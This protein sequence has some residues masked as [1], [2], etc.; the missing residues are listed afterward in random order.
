MATIT[1]IELDG[2]DIGAVRGSR[3]FVVSAVFEQE[4]Q[5]SINIQ[6]ISF[7][8]SAYNLNSQLL[9]TKW[10]NN[11]SEGIPFSISI[12]DTVTPSNSI[13]FDFYTDFTKMKFLSAVETSVAMIKESSLNQF[14]FRAEGITMLSMEQKGILSLVDRQNFPYVVENRKTLLEK[15]QILSQGFGVLKSLAD[16]VHKI[17]NIASDLPTLG[18]AIPAAINLTVT[19][20][21]IGTLFQRL[22]TLF[23]EIQDSFFPPVRYHSGIKPKNFIEKTVINY[24]GYSNVEFG[25]FGTWP[26]II[27]QLTWLPSKNNEI[28]LPVNGGNPI[29]G[30]LKPTNKGYYLAGTIETLK[31]QFRLKDA[32]INNVYHL[33]P[34]KDPFWTSN[35]GY[36][37]PNV[38]V[39]ENPAG[40]GTKRPNY[41]DIKAVTDI[42]YLTDDSDLHTLDDLV[43]EQ[44]PNTTGKL[45]S[46][47]TVRP[48]NVTNQRRVLLNGSKTVEIPYC[49]AVRK[50][51]LDDLLDLFVGSSAAIGA[52]KELI[53]ERIQ[54]FASIFAASNPAMEEF[55]VNLGNRTGA[56]KVEN[57]FFSV[58]KMALL[59]DNLSGEPR[60]V[61][62]FGD[63]IGA[64]ALYNDFHSY[65]SFIPGKR[66]P[67]NL[68]ET[69][70]KFIFEGVRI[71]FGLNDFNTILNNAYFTTES[72]E[73]GK[74]IK[75][76]WNVYGDFATIDYWIYNNWMNNIE[77]TTV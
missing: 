29:S 58:P 14:N 15:I 47:T 70:A 24:M 46:V 21:A 73:E 5:P 49:L 38:L 76:D 56:M 1:N 55:I 31:D 41:E 61:A 77:E 52:M 37:M 65:D 13:D 66:N 53:E 68:N 20:T 57:H 64:K 60:I 22:K 74:F 25:T 28:G 32:I 3:D 30:I 40:N 2:Q 10:A 9:L 43:N 4:V 26:Q 36:V 50:D 11:P 35:S 75:C 72:G 33:R 34:A 7:T 27:E 67:N 44:N 39:E 12:Q 63:L 62:N 6:D 23:Q 45:Y 51:Q 8:D 69:A 16:E 19:I 54:E 18:G 48:V 42:H 17:I 59:K 71:P